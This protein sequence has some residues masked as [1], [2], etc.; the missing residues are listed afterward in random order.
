MRE[1]LVL[2]SPMGP[3]KEHYF[4]PDRDGKALES[5]KEMDIKTTSLAIVDSGLEG[6]TE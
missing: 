3:P 6:R 2:P 5:F 1:G 4:C